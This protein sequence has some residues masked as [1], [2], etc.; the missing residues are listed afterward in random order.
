MLVLYCIFIS[1]FKDAKTKYY[2]TVGNEKSLYDKW[3]GS[4]STP[5]TLPSLALVRS[6]TSPTI[7]IILN[8]KCAL[9]HLHC[10][11]GAQ[12]LKKILNENKYGFFCLL[13]NK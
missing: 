13:V 2:A 3:I 8:I 7:S 5:P 1:E 10:G 4:V 9:P 12:W 6:S 11:P